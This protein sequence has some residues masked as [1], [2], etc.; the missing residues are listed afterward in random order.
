MKM[1][2]PLLATAALLYAS[3]CVLPHAV[4]A[5]NAD[6]CTTHKVHDEC[7]RSNC[8]AISA[9]GMMMARL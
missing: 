3:L 5:Q 8:T 9:A 6:D 1:R 4:H 7:V 2:V